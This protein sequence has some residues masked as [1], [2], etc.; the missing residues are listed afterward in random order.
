MHI[1]WL[2]EGK[3]VVKVLRI[4]ETHRLAVL[5]ALYPEGGSS[6]IVAEKDAFFSPVI[7]CSIRDVRVLARQVTCHVRAKNMPIPLEVMS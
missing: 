6:E 5:E 4:A 7:V 1:G 3:N 2:Q